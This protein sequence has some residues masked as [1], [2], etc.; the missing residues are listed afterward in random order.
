M[1]TINT[2]IGELARALA[3]YRVRILCSTLGK[4]LYK[5]GMV[6]AQDGMAI[7]R[8]MEAAYH[9]WKQRDPETTKAIAYAFIRAHAEEGCPAA[10]ASGASEHA[11]R[12]CLVL[13]PPSAVLGTGIT[14]E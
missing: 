12:G 5:R 9:A 10:K 2:F 4:I 3:A 14:S 6:P 1:D 13:V 8:V 7:A 11:P